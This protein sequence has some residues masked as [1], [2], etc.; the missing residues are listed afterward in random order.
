MAKIMNIED[1]INSFQKAATNAWY[2]KFHDFRFESDKGTIV[3]SGY[4]YERS[5]ENFDADAKVTENDKLLYEKDSGSIAN[6][7]MR[8]FGKGRFGMDKEKLNA[9]LR[10]K[11]KDVEFTFTEV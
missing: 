9:Y 5:W 1:V 4:V 8:E 3:V 10:D 2:G 6:Y 7:V 11:Y